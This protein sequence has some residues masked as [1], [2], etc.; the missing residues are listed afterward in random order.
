MSLDQKPGPF[1]T[2]DDWSALKDAVLRFE[3]AWCQGSRPAIDD[4]LPAGGLRQ[5]LLTELV[6]I[7]LELRLKTGEAARAE[8][9]LSRYPE[10]A[11]DHAA[12]LD[13]IVAEYQVR[14]RA[15]PH[16]SGDEF[17]RRF[18]QYHGELP[19]RIPPATVAGRDTPPRKGRPSPEVPSEV[20]GYEVLELL[21]RGG[22]GVV[23]LARQHSLDRLVALKFL[24]AACA[25][26][27]VWLGRFRREALTASALNHPHI[28]TIYDTGECAGRPDGRQPAVH[29][30]PAP[31][32]SRPRGD[33][34]GPRPL[35][36]GPC[37]S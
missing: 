12:A 2:D 16:L 19:E 27:P 22:M 8:E 29:G 17:L 21:G 32:P 9:Y 7:D 23:Y 30:G 20:P 11:G 3:G 5:R 37:P 36:A 26:D 4:Y 13:L 33:R 18:P 24:P 15:E 1:L 28:C 34:P 35:G 10:F 14:R 25:R 6:H 31:L